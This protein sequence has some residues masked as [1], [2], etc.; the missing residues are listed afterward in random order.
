[1]KDAMTMEQ[2]G[3]VLIMVSNGVDIEHDIVKCC[4]SIVKKMNE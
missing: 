4:M 1:M 2:D 3:M